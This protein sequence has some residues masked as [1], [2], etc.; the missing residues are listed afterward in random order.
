MIYDNF[1]GERRRSKER[2]KTPT[3]V[4]DVAL[5]ATAAKGRLFS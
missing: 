3:K 2:P 5:R 4:G 1:L